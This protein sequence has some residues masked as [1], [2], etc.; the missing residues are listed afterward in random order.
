M[1]GAKAFFSR[2]SGA[3][4]ETVVSGTETVAALLPFLRDWKRTMQNIEDQ[5][6]AAQA[7]RAELVAERD[8]Q[9]LAVVE[10]D[11]TARK[12]VDRLD[13]SVA[14]LDRE[15]SRLHIARQKAGE[16][17]AIDNAAEAAAREKQRL[18][19]VRDQMTELHA[20]AADLDLKAAEHAAALKAFSD[21]CRD[22][23]TNVKNDEFHSLISALG[24]AVVIYTNKAL[25]ASGYGFSKPLFATGRDSIKGWVPDTDHV[26][27]LAA[28]NPSRA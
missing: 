19:D 8:P 5:I 22:L 25:S 7:R 24:G 21:R 6:T 12:T 13:K 11:D 4:A 17:V 26:V 27:T 20:E 14:D 2:L 9:I 1:I 3:A 18:A 10:G 15:L 28:A 23:R 16:R